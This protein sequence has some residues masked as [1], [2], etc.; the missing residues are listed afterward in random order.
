MYFL[1]QKN[2]Y[3]YLLMYL[4]Y[5]SDHMPEEILQPIAKQTGE[6]V[7]KLEITTLIDIIA[8]DDTI[9]DLHVSAGDCVAYRMNWDIVKQKQFWIVSTEFMELFLKYLMQLDSDKI[10]KF[11][12]EKDMDFSYIDKNSVSYRV[13]AFMKLGKIAVVMRKINADA[14]PL[15]SLM[16]EDI[17]TSLKNTILSRKTGLFLVTWPTGSGKSTSLVAMLEHLNHTVNAHM[18]TI[19]DP[20]EFVFKPDKCLISQRELWWDTRSFLNALR[21]AMRE[22][23]NIVFVWEIRDTETAEAALNLAETWHIVFSTLHTSSA[24]STINRYI[25]LFPPEIQSSVSDR[26]A[27]SLSGVLSQFLVKS[28]DEKWRIWLYELMLNTTAIRNNIKKGD[29]R[30]VDNII[31]TSSSQGMVSMRSYAQ[32]LIA[33]WLIDENVVSRLFLWTTNV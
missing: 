24:S 30:G 5:Y 7:M 20:I 25:S 4:F 3:L 1:T 28:K 19:E 23:P 17:A 14:K 22:D 16:Y 13:N 27:D 21:S 33:Q 18:I 29:I 32:R 11:W 10:A 26:L 12:A 6:S 31:E 8:K 15:E 9:S 2:K